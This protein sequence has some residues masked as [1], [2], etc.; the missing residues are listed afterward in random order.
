V[1]VCV[2]CDE[3][4]HALDGSSSTNGQ[5]WR[6]DDC[7]QA[8]SVDYAAAFDRL[9]GAAIDAESCAWR[10]MEETASDNE[11]GTCLDE[12]SERLL[13]DI[14]TGLLDATAWRSYG[15]E[16]C[17]DRVEKL[18]KALREIE[19]W[20]PDT[21]HTEERTREGAEAMYRIAVTALQPTEQ[22][23]TGVKGGD[24]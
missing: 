8:A 21:E 9:Y 19:S 23:E 2:L 1:R 24:K 10:L 12:S 3:P 20:C 15:Q 14:Y 6:H 16:R 18:E 11:A 5:P 17:P 4:I 13:L 22:T 7:E